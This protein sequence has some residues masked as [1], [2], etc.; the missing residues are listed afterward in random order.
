[1]NVGTEG[2][3]FSPS[4]VPFPSDMRLLGRA[5]SF[6]MNTASAGGIT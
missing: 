3:F 5:S 1:M 4:D 2:L 6:G